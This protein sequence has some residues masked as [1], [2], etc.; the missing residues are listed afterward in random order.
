MRSPK[1]TQKILL[2]KPHPRLATVLGLQQFMLLEPL[3]FG[4][5]AAAVPEHEVRV[6]D[7]RLHRNPLRVFDKTLTAFKP[8][9]V[10][11]T[12]YSHEANALKY[13]ALKA[14]QQLPNA[15]IVAGGHHATS[16]PTDLNIPQI[17]AIVRG[18]GCDPFRTLV[19]AVSEGE[20][21]VGIESVLIPGPDFDFEAAAGWPH[22]CDPALIPRPRRDLWDRR[23]Y[24]SIWPAEQLPRFGRVF[25]DVAMVRTSWG[26]RMKCSFCVVPFL[27]Q[28]RHRPRPVESVVDELESLEQDYVYFC[29]DEN[30]INRQF[31]WELAEAIEARGIKK[32]YFAWTRATTVNRD[33][34]LLK[35]WHDIGLDSV[36]IGFEFIND[37]ELKASSKG[38]TVAA[39][40]RAL[41]NLRAMGVVVHA[42]FMI[43]S[44]YTA[45]D[46]E[47]LRGYVNA[48]PPSQCSFTV[49]TPIPGTADYAEY[50]KQFIVD[51]SSAYDLHDCMHPLLKMSIP[52]REY[53]RHFAT[54]VIEGIQ[55][56]PLRVNR[57]LAP[58]A[59]MFRVWRAERNYC[60]GYR[61]LYRDYPSEMWD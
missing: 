41:D 61:N 29:D 46:F 5:L 20:E 23:S 22:P 10:G 25:P 35:K 44:D 16:V 21:L 56:T 45:D 19:E 52:L 32:R 58:P 2:V 31:A 14:R 7:L 50:E 43:R 4:Y 47:K 59:D 8:D 9:I 38:C 36:F 15:I 17:D 37:E 33:T 26:C 57:H 55:K 27:S 24:Y 39:N 12:A 40:E 1:T 51:S 30:F 11:L 13:L 49:F 18:D 28:Q 3:E 34:E 42:A 60:K 53:S 6:L 54:Q 48:M